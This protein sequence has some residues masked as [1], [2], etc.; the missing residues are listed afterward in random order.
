MRGAAQDMMAAQEDM[1]L[2][3]SALQEKSG[4][5]AAGG[6]MRAGARQPDRRLTEEHRPIVPPAAPAATPPT[7]TATLLPPASNTLAAS[8][9]LALQAPP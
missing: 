9:V 3:D 7:R 1:R 5:W 2:W 4:E 8:W 6:Q